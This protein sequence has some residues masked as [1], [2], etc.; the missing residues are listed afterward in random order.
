MEAL[1][2]T[3]PANTAGPQRINSSQTPRHP[4]A[5]GGPILDIDLAAMARQLQ[6]EHYGS[7]TRNAMTLVKH[8]DFRVVLATVRA[9]A[10][11]ARH[12]VRGTVLLQ[13]L[14]GHVRIRVF[15]EILDVTADHIVSLDSNLDHEVTAIE[16]ALLLITIAWPEAMQD[17]SQQYLGAEALWGCGVDPVAEAIG[18]EV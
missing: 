8:R 1:A 10:H 2:Y 9:G 17:S 13:V 4:I 6:C 16:D 18:S 14:R 12:S 7:G 11:L 5:T 15:E 3:H